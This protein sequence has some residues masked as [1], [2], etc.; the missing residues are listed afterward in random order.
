MAMT[1]PSS[2][3]SAIVAKPHINQK[4]STITAGITLLLII[5]SSLESLRVFP[6]V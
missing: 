5:L 2:M 1:G 6:G 4:N 3:S